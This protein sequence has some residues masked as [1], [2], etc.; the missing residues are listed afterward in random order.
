MITYLPEIYP[1]EFVG[2]QSIQD[3]RHINEYYRSC[4]VKNQIHRLKNLSAI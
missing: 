1:D 4:T 2:M 3:I